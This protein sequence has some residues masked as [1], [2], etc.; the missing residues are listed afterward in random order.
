VRA[1]RIAVKNNKSTA[2]PV[3]IRLTN[4]SNQNEVQLWPNNDDFRM[5]EPGEKVTKSR[6]IPLQ[7]GPGDEVR[8]RAYW[9]VGDPGAHN[10]AVFRLFDCGA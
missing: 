5:M 7:Y 1:A 2:Q 10:R 8:V 6:D 3:D 4:H 9:V